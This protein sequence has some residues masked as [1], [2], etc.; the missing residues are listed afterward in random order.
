METSI[1]RPLGV[2]RPLDAQARAAGSRLIEHVAR[3]DPWAGLG[4]TAPECGQARN[5][6][7]GIGAKGGITEGYVFFSHLK[8]RRILQSK[9][10]MGWR[11]P[12]ALEGELPK[13]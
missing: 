5:I 2:H 10:H 9:N 4:T 11:K 13:L 12:G 6:C 3:T 7:S 1:G 8:I